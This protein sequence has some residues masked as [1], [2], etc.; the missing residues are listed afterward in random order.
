MDIKGALSLDSWLAELDFRVAAED[1]EVRS[2]DSMAP[3]AQISLMQIYRVYGRSAPI[4]GFFDLYGELKNVYEAEQAGLL[5]GDLDFYPRFL[6]AIGLLDARITAENSRARF[7]Q[8]TQEI[9]P[10]L[11]RIDSG[12]QLPLN[13]WRNLIVDYADLIQTLSADKDIFLAV[14]K[15]PGNTPVRW[16]RLQ[17]TSPKEQEIEKLRREDPDLFSRLQQE[18]QQ[19]RE[20][21]QRIQTRITEDGHVPSIRNLFGRPMNVG[22]DPVTDEISVYDTDGEV[23]TPAEFG[24]KVKAKNKASKEVINPN[25]KSGVLEGLRKYTDQQVEAAASSGNTRYV[26]LTDDPEKD[27][28]LTKIYRVADIGGEPVVV[29]GRYRG[30]PVPSL[31]NAAGRQIEGGAY[32]LDYDTGTKITRR[33]AKNPDGSLSKKKTREPYLTVSGGKLYLQVSGE[34]YFTPIREELTRLAG[35]VPTIEAI[36]GT[37]RSSYTFEPKDFNIIRDRVGSMAMSSAASKLLSN[38]FE[39]LTKAGRA[40]ESGNLERFS[41]ER[42]GLK[43]PLRRHTMKALAWMEANGDKGIC[44]LDTGMGKTVTAIA[45]MMNLDMRNKSEGTNGRYLYVCEKDLLGNL[46]GEL[47]KF[48][49]KPV[50]DQMAARVDIIPYRK[51]T[52]LRK[53]DQ[54]YGDNYIAIYFDEAH[55]HL[56]SKTKGAYKAAVTCKAKHKVLLTASPMVKAPR[57]VFTLASVANG[58]DLNSPEGRKQESKFLGFYTQDVGG[59]PVAVSR[60]PNA[61]KDFRV[62]VKRNLFFSDKTSV[63]EEDSRIEQL[64]KETVSVTMPPELEA[65]YKAEM[66][67][68]LAGLKDLAAVYRERPELA[69]EA[70]SRKLTRPLANLT[71]LSDVPNRVIPGAPNPK[72]NR[73]VEIINQISMSDRTLLFSDSMELAEDTFA[74]LQKKFPGKGHVLGLKNMIIYSTPSGDQMKFTA[75]KYKDPETGRAVKA[76]EW[77]TFVLT[78]ILGLGTTQTQYP[79]HTAVLTGSYAVGQNLQSFGHVIHLDRDTW[80]NETMKQR[81]SR[82]WR[83]G[84]K[85]P[86]DEYT[87][88]LAYSDQV[89]GPGASQTLDQIRKV[90]QEIDASLFNQVVIDSQ[91]ERLGEEWTEIKKQRSLL[92]KVDRRML[93]RA[94]S[95]Y[96]QQMGEQETE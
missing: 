14:R 69:F 34:Q 85:K 28:V 62:W 67:N 81:T 86:V 13:L 80:S 59:R 8:K 23:L 82:A 95:P 38:Y 61:A 76:D 24:A 70:A 91:V 48:L 17:K 60:D 6:R 51:F 29:A 46:V 49:E 11:R 88:D 65:A 83:S 77:K 87:V 56:G 39:E 3:I 37:R 73:A 1:L 16:L 58:L 92:H 15:L 35:K 78:K 93:E 21:G 54:T 12:G 31:V 96:A 72:I 57:E 74:D 75:R 4:I 79:V 64:R 41:S 36:T 47:Y 20:I 50:A 10:V 27:T 26:S 7:E 19:K 63:T 68:V 2:P 90:V 40:A 71:R 84:N 22:V 42:L 89:A 53:Q 44:A 5:Q 33:D 52:S 25:W 55:L 66:Q 9:L 30:I 94:L 45:S 32:Y 43:L 18:T